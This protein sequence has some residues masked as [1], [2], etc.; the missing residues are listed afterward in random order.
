LDPVQ[1]FTTSYNF[2][3]PVIQVSGVRKTYGRTVAVDEV[4]FEVNEGEIFGLIGP[5]GAGKSTTMECIEGLRKPDRGIISVL[6]LD[7]IRHVYKLQERIGVQLQQAQLQKRIKVW[8]AVDLWASLYRKK[9]IDGE[10]LLE[11]L[12]LADKRDAWFMNLSG[13]QKQRLFIALA[14]INDPEVVFLDEL[15]TGLDPQS[16]R[17]IWELV[18]GIRDRGKTVFLTTHLMEEAER[19]CD[20]VAIIEH[21]RIIDIDKPESLV[22]RHCPERTVVLVTDDPLAEKRFRSIPG[23]E[24]VICTDMRFTIRGRGDDLVTQVIHCLSENQIRVTDFRT[25]LPN[26]EDVFL[27]LTGHSIRD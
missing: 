6:G 12:G 2:M 14:L 10:H 15:T 24:A 18:R 13:G 16:R 11:Q 20:R 22:D 17:A 5:N 19:L 3:R 7:P 8:E 27:K 4:S 23:V 26:L 25:I 9:S 1:E 21:G